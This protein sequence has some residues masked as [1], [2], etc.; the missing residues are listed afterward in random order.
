MRC[1]GHYAA[2]KYASVPMKALIHV[3]VSL[4]HIVTTV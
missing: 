4:T 3:D 2:G 1:D